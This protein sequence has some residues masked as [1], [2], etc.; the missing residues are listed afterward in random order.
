MRITTAA[1]AAIA[2][3]ALVAAPGRAQAVD[4]VEADLLGND[5]SSIGKI[6]A[7]GG[8]NATVL[9]ITVAPGKV[10][11]G[12][13]GIHFHAVGDCSDTEKFQASKSHIN[14]AAANHGLLNPEGPDNGDLPNVYAAADGSVNA[15]VS[16]PIPLGGPYGLRDG[17][18]AA[19]VMHASEDDHESQ[20]I[21][22][23]GAR[24]ACAVIR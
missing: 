17:D 6:V 4:T 2:A 10:P 13:H 18:G 23:A 3:V 1:F 22:G 9:R 15:E 21:G 16:S 5:G 12:W 7:R 20:P 19:L 11:P 24:I 8:A 14:H